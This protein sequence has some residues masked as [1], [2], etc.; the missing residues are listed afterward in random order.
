MQDKKHRFYIVSALKDTKV[1]LKG[2]ILPSTDPIF[3]LSS[4][5]VGV[6]VT[7]TLCSIYTVIYAVLAHV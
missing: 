7:Q 3:A 6:K 2:K 1:D 5:N 4:L